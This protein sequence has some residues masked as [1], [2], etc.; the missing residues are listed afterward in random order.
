MKI[1]IPV[2][3]NNRET[4]VCISFGRTPYF[5]MHDTETKEDKFLINDA[6]ESRGGAG[7]KAAQTIVDHKIDVLLTPRCGE[8]AAEVLKAGDTKIYKTT[9][10]T[11]LE[12]INAYLSGKLSE[13]HEIHAGFHGHGEN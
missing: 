9:G 5:W 8:N 7:I 3:E 13:L 1:V 12:N 6:A 10:G 11:A 2:D 4:D